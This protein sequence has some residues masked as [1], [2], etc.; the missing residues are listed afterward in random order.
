LVGS[1]HINPEDNRG[2]LTD[3]VSQTS[4]LPYFNVLDLADFMMYQ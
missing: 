1:K 4:K 2:P 3:F